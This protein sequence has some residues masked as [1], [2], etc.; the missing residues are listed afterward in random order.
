MYS[1]FYNIYNYIQL[2]MA[3]IL[4]GKKL[5]EIRKQYIMKKDI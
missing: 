2:S 3:Y 1:D 5:M 4:I